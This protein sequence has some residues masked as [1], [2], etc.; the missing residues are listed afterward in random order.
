MDKLLYST[1]SFGRFPKSHN[2]ASLPTPLYSW[3]RSA[4]YPDGASL[5]AIETTLVSPNSHALLLLCFSIGNRASISALWTA[6]V[7]VRAPGAMVR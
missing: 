1:N 5:E 3:A 7:P 6:A 4:D 2:R